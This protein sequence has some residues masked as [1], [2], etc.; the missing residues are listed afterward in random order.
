VEKL[1]A[2]AE[3][4]REREAEHLRRIEELKAQ[5]PGGGGA[6]DSEAE[7]VLQDRLREMKARL[8]EVEPPSPHYSS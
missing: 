8:E 5:G 1:T 4:L 7:A 2:Q 6:A 3:R